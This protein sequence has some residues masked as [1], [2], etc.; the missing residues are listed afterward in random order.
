VITASNLKYG[1]EIRIA[2]MSG[3]KEAPGETEGTGT[4]QSE[5]HGL[6]GMKTGQLGHF[7]PSAERGKGR[8][9]LSRRLIYI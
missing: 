3:Q 2:N 5:N 1:M 4:R 9:G 6:E 8:S 7:V